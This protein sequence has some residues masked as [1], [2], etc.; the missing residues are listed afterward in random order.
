MAKYLRAKIV[1]LSLFFALCCLE[2][3]SRF[4]YNPFQVA[5]FVSFRVGEEAQSYQESSIPELAYEPVP[6]KGEFNSLGLRD[7]ENYEWH[8]SPGHVRILIIGDSITFGTGVPKEFTYAKFLERLLNRNGQKFEVL[9]GGVEGYNTVQQ[10]AWF[11][12]HLYKLEPDVVI[13][14]YCLNDRGFHIPEFRRK[15]NVAEI[16]FYSYNYPYVFPLPG[17]RFFL[18]HVRSYALFQSALSGLFMKINKSEHVKRYIPE[19]SS[20]PME[21]ALVKLRNYCDEKGIKLFV[22]IFPY[23]QSWK[24]YFLWPEHQWIKQILKSLKIPYFDLYHIYC[25]FPPKWL[26]R[27]KIHPSVFGHY[28]AAL[29]IYEV[30]FRE[31][32][33]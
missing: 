19:E 24:N 31:V 20:K 14:G 29:A 33:R 8:K 17:N 15:G 18:T 10:I 7:Y 32:D 5:E 30:F 1:F 21:E 4:F 3:L 2:L 13:V 22:I 27:D 26:R 23:F 12:H 11:F 25:F 6:G 28:L 9:N 16:I